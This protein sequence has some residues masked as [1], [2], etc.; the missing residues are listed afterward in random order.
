[1]ESPSRLCCLSQPPSFNKTCSECK[2]W[3]L[4]GVKI[5][6]SR[7]N[8][9]VFQFKC[10]H[11]PH[12][13]DFYLSIEGNVAISEGGRKRR[14]DTSL[15][16]TMPKRRAPPD[17]KDKDWNEFKVADNFYSAGYYLSVASIPDV[18]QHRRGRP[19]KVANHC[20]TARFQRRCQE[21]KAMM[22][23]ADKERLELIATGRDQGKVL[24]AL[25]SS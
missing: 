8:A 9:G 19:A 15:L 13:E 6:K 24:V 16:Q 20:N 4:E 1:M 11:G 17:Y 3:R 2:I 10:D 22:A 23:L 12:T 18:I 7:W 5:R 21:L 14:V 25:S